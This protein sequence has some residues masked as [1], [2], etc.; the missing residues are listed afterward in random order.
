MPIVR[1]TAGNGLFSA[2]G[3]SGEHRRQRKLLQPV[4]QPRHLVTY[5]Q[6]IVEI[7]RRVQSSWQD[8]QTIGIE[9]EMERITMGI[10]GQTFF[11]VDLLNEARE[12]GATIT[13]LFA[14]F[15]EELQSPWMFPSWIPTPHNRRVRAAVSHLEET[16]MPI[17]HK[18]RQQLSGRE[19]FLSL[20]LQ[21]R[22]EDGAPLSEREVRD[23]AMTMF[24]AG[25]ETMAVALTWTWYLL[26]QHPSVY[27]YDRARAE[28]DRAVGERDP[29]LDDLPQMPFVLQVF[30]ES[31]RLYP[32]ADI[33]SLRVAL[34]DVEIDG[35]RIARRMPIIISPY[36]LHRKTEIFP[37]PETFDPER[38]TAE[39]EKKLPR[40]AYLPF[41]AGARVCI[42]QH[43]ALMEGHLVLA[44]LLQSVRFRLDE[45]QRVE[46][47]AVFTTRPKNDIQMIVQRR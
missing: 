23:Q 32:P 36:A 3:H 42:G 45:N 31:L 39:N 40:C 13:R 20:L 34:R 22:Y 12:L 21:A 38:F 41:G 15:G 30:K 18:R 26:S 8:G 33:I 5:T 44:A 16:L 1:A 24:M 14:L 2:F 47:Q 7:A 25:H 10:A 9:R 6:T 27:D 19:D 17:I 37:D 46:A 43:F 35:Y 28:V 11:G 29:V 4:F